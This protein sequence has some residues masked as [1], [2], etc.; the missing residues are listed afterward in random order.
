MYLRVFLSMLAFVILIF[1]FP[2]LIFNDR[3]E[4]ES[5]LNAVLAYLIILYSSIKLSYLSIKNEQRLLEMTFWIFSYMWMGLTPFAHAVVGKYSWDVYYYPPSLFT[6][7]LIMVIVGL[8]FYEIGIL[9]SNHRKKE[10]FNHGFNIKMK[11]KTIPMN[12]KWIT[13]LS[14]ISIVISL[15]LYIKY[16]GLG[17][18]FATRGQ[19]GDLFR[20]TTTSVKLVTNYLKKVPILVCL[21]IALYLNKIITDNKG[22]DKKYIILIGLLMIVNI[23]VSNPVTNGRFWAGTVFITLMIIIFKWGTRAF[24]LWVIGL[25]TSLLVIFPYA[26]LFRRIN[27]RLNIKPFSYQLTEK[28]DYDAFQQIMNTI[29]Y[30]DTLGVEWGR[31]MMGSFLFFVPRGIWE[32]KPISTGELVAEF[33]RYDFTNLS[34]PLWAESYIDF[35]AIGIGLIFL[36]YGFI[37][38]KIQIRFIR[39][40]FINNLTFS[41]I[42]VPFLTGYQVFLLRGDLMNGIAYMS[43]F[44]LFSYLFLYIKPN[45]SY[46]L[47]YA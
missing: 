14:I 43:T 2:L 4:I 5:V 16:G 20:E 29:N 13:L 46:Q 12:K 36:I 22:I 3:R 15:L 30:V 9:I 44:I 10:K 1:I 45:T 7:A 33:S 41:R 28:G 32:S 6:R 18:I 47:S 17:S 31:Q 34:A 42:L 11:I 8:V 37:S 27:G 26:D 35:G 40:N 24:S 38:G 25:T 19:M 39:D 23:S 21:I